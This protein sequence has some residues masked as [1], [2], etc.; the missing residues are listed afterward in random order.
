LEVKRSQVQVAAKSKICP[1][2]VRSQSWP[3][4][5]QHENRAIPDQVTIPDRPVS[6]ILL[7]TGETGSIK[8]GLVTRLT[9]GPA[10]G[11]RVS[12]SQG[13]SV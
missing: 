3:R 8:P 4:Q 11:V 2:S 7:V 10:L 5:R 13:L 6:A 9:T 1:A 12:C